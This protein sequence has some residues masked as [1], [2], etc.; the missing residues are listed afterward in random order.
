MNELHH[1]TEQ[2]LSVVMAKWGKEAIAERNELLAEN[3][4]LRDE[5]S[6]HKDEMSAQCPPSR[7][8]PDPENAQFIVASHVG[9][10]HY[11]IPQDA[12]RSKAI[13]VKWGVLHY[14]TKDGEKV[15]DDPIHDGIDTDEFEKWPQY[16]YW[17]GREEYVEYNGDD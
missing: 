8:C 2:A 15:E 17:V 10:R 7:L 11:R 14:W 4:R 5:L 9:E 16:E 13:Y 1:L 6:R 12:D 3:Q